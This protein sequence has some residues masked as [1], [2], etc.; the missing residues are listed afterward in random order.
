MPLEDLSTF[1]CLISRAE[2]LSIAGL[3]RNYKFLKSYKVEMLKQYLLN[4]NGLNKE[5]KE[6]IE[7]QTEAINAIIEEIKKELTKQT[8]EF[9]GEIKKVKMHNIDEFSTRIR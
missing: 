8:N 7:K 3:K 4:A 5:Y 9:K 1:E 2:F 6:N